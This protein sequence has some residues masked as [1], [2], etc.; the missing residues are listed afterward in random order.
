[1]AQFGFHLSSKIQ[2]SMKRW[3]YILTCFMIE[4][5]F[6]ANRISRLGQL[7]GWR[8]RSPRTAMGN[9]QKFA[10]D[11]QAENLFS[12]LAI[13]TWYQEN[14]SVFLQCCISLGLFFFHKNDKI[15]SPFCTIGAAG[16]SRSLTS[17]WQPLKP[18]R[19][20]SMRCRNLSCPSHSQA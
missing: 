13:S 3:K 2:I 4:H 6:P 14:A 9:R 11:T 18:Y 5:H 7:F 16:S 20:Y 19:P 8:L 12:H 17:L 10:P 1:M 15:P